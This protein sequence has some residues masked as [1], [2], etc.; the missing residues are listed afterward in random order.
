[1]LARAPPVLVIRAA[2][3]PVPPLVCDVVPVNIMAVRRSLL[4]LALQIQHQTA[5]VPGIGRENDQCKYEEEPPQAVDTG[6]LVIS[7][8]RGMQTTLIKIFL[9]NNVDKMMKLSPCDRLPSTQII[10]TPQNHAISAESC[11]ICRGESEFEEQ[12][13]Q[14]SLAGAREPMTCPQVHVND[15]IQCLETL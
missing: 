15:V 2:A 4:Y 11:G 14:P 10:D 12:P 6:I 13:C 7:G 8:I 3:L 5:A 1:M 9:I